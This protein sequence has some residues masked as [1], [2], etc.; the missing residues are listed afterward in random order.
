MHNFVTQLLFPPLSNPRLHSLCFVVSLSLCP[1]PSINFFH[2]FALFCFQRALRLSLVVSAIPCSC[3]HCKGI[4]WH[5]LRSNQ[6]QVV[7]LVVCHTYYS[8]S[9]KCK[10]PERTITPGICRKESERVLDSSS[11]VWSSSHSL[12]RQLM[13]ECEWERQMRRARFNSTNEILI[14]CNYN[15]LILT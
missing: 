8:P 2:S 12:G 13:R 7:W 9:F 1:F 11:Q 3:A 15:T 4:A 10:E 6:N 5:V 14:L